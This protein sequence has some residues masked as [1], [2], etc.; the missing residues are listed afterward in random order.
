[1]KRIKFLSMAICLITALAFTSCND[2]DSYSGL[3]KEDIANCYA[4]VNGS[5]V[6]QLIYASENKAD[7]KDVTDTCAISVE[8]KTDSVLTLKSFPISQLAYLVT[9]NDVANAIKE[10]APHDIS[11]YYGFTYN[12]PITFLVNPMTYSFTANYGGKEHKLQIAFYSN[13]SYSFGRY[14]ATNRQL[15][16]Q[17]VEAA[18]YVDGKET[19]YL[20]KGYAFVVYA[21]K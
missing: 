13:S 4:A 10:Q 21:K 11:C 1:M 14:D 5:Y 19:R 20:T 18:I 7:A 16:M 3:S 9:D 6:G 17:I 15:S 8:I 2:D 12:N